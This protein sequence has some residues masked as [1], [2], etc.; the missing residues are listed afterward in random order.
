LAVMITIYVVLDGF[1][2]GVGAL[3]L[4]L[5]RTEPEREAATAAIGPVWNGNEV[6]L[7]ASGGVLFMAFPAAYAAAFSGLYFGL[8]FVLWLL[9]ARG[10]ALELRHQ[11]VNPLWRS[12]C[13]V[14]FTLSS[15]ALALVFGVALGNVV[16]GVP[17]N[18]DGYFHLTLFECLN[19]YALLIGVFGL[20]T[21]CAHGAGFLAVRGEGALAVRARARAR[22]LTVVAAVL[23]VALIGPTASV[24]S[25]MFSNLLDHPWRLIFPALATA[26]LIFTIVSQHRGAW[27]RAFAG[28]SLFIVGLLTTMAAGLYPYVLPAHEHRPFGLTVD[29]AA[30]GHKALVNAIVW[31][32]LG[33]VL[34]AVYFTFAY[35]MF[36]RTATVRST[37][38]TIDQSA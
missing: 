22:L 38:A 6:W 11:I 29:N 19:W 28:S 18:A 27:G 7:I 5:A 36:F 35:R 26:A 21:L 31:W 30:A 3:H 16:R 33:M 12:A 20:V 23:F 9:V 24:R 25:A 17:L 37:S 15:A 34:A 8:I 1:D 10:L 4:D 32:P 14:V 2:L 13:D